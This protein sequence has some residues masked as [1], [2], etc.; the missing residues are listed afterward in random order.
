MNQTPP[1]AVTIA[2]QNNER[3]QLT[4]GTQPLAITQQSLA[5]HGDNKSKTVYKENF[6]QSKTGEDAFGA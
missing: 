1:T 4:A 3:T 6:S 2:L 5:T